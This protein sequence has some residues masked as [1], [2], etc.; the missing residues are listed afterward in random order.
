LA[1]VALVCLY[2]GYRFVYRPANSELLGVY[3][4]VLALPWSLLAAALGTVGLALGV[5]GGVALNAWLLFRLAG[6]RPPRPPG[7]APQPAPRGVAPP[8]DE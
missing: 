5:P 7:Q 4:V 8:T 2:L 3:L 6:G 1:V